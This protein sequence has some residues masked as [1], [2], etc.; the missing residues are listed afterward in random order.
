MPYFFIRFFSGILKLIYFLCCV[1]H[2]S[3]NTIDEGLEDFSGFGLAQF[4]LNFSSA[5]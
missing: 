5:F 3:F 2:L 1:F 4:S